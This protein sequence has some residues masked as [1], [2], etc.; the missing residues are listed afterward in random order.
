MNSGSEAVEAAIKIARITAYTGKGIA[1]NKAEIIS[2][3]NSFHGRT[4]GAIAL[5]GDSIY[6]NFEPHLPGFRQIPFGD[7]E[8]LKKAINKNT[9][10]AVLEPIQAE[11]GVNIPPS[12]Y[13]RECR[14][15][16]KNAEILF[17]LD[18]IQTGFGRTGAKFCWQHENAQPDL[19]LGGKFA[20]GNQIPV[21][22]VVGPKDIID[23]IP[24]GLHGSTYGANPLGCA[25]IKAVIEVFEE[26]KLDQQAKKTGEYLLKKLEEEIGDSPLVKEIRGKGLLIG[27][28]LSAKAKKARKYTE[29]LL[30]KEHLLVKERGD[31]VIAL[32]PQLNIQRDLVN[33]GI[34][35]IKKVL[36]K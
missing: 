33:K 6:K 18:E 35:K 20:G 1:R 28:E 36:G 19:M 17:I 23:I 22:F 24:S 12:G 5:S 14:E 7:S 15:I 3:K 27:I 32:T 31:K 21:S 4:P 25:I 26:E 30:Q 13:L 29:E 9:C 11:G 34:E 2:A 8:A 10:A 16:C